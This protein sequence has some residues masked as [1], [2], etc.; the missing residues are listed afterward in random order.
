MS[1]FNKD[2]KIQRIFF[3]LD[4]NKKDYHFNIHVEF[5]EIKI[6]QLQYHSTDTV[7][8]TVFRIKTQLFD[9]TYDA[10]IQ[11]PFFTILP[12]PANVKDI[13]MYNKP[14]SNDQEFITNNVRYFNQISFELYEDSPDTILPLTLISDAHLAEYLVYLELM[15]ITK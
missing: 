11:Q 15:I 9:Q 6:L 1:F 10:N 7:N 13:S 2:T 14:V 4:R 3:S 12:K 8:S 5:H